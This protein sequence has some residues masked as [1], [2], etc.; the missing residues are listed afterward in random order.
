MQLVVASEVC[1]TYRA[2]LKEK[3]CFI[4]GQP[5]TRC[6]RDGLRAFLFSSPVIRAVELVSDSE[7]LPRRSACGEMCLA[8]KFDRLFIFFI[9][10]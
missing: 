2:G 6:G 10:I 4:M 7:H 8:S 5:V 1:Q 3:A 9:F